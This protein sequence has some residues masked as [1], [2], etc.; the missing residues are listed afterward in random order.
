MRFSSFWEAFCYHYE[1]RP[2][3]PFLVD[4]VTQFSFKDA[5]VAVE[6][7]AL[8]EASAA[9]LQSNKIG[10]IIKWLRLE[11]ERSLSG[12]S[13][14]SDILKTSGS[15]GPPKHFQLSLGSQMVTAEAIN[16]KILKRRNLDEVVLLP[17]SHSSARGRIRAAL[18]RGSTIFLS[19][20][21]ISLKKIGASVLKDSTFGAA[22]TPAT[23]RYLRERLGGE[24][25]SFFGG[26]LSLEFGSAP[27]RQ[28]EIDLLRV[29]APP[30]VDLLMHYGLTEASR[31]FLRDLRVH[32]WND[33][34]EPMPHTSYRLLEDGEILIS[35]PHTAL[36]FENLGSNNP[37]SEVAT[38][39]LCAREDGRLKL[40]GR[41]KN[42]IN[43]GGFKIHPESIE[44]S[45]EG[46]SKF[47]HLVIVGT[48]DLLLG[49]RPAVF[50]GVGEGDMAWNLISDISREEPAWAS[51]KVIEIDQIP[52]IGPGKIDRRHLTNLAQDWRK[53]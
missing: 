9:A 15:T 39:D 19:G 43:V 4:G 12:Q 31:S 53:V 11:K 51:A 52:L 37:S 38:G 10:S 18:L 44:A 2:H 16:S 7:C 20:A 24:F 27:L 49:E 34:G 17:L 13:V 45:F 23:Y 35:G 8:E 29:S 33:L 48:E 42:I 3:A 26:L 40:V 28:D 25:W 5:A 1:G 46:A 14:P 6:K 30:H 36:P 50:V 22:V 21:P 41:K 47:T 32:D